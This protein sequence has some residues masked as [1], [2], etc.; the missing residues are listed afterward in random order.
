MM[1]RKPLDASAIALMLGLCVFWGLQQVAVKL[2]LPHMGAIMQ[3][4]LR[5]AIAAMLVCI[6]IWWRGGASL[7]AGTLR[8]GMTAGTLFA[9]EFLCVAAGLEFTTAS[10]MSVFLYTAP[11]FTVL[12]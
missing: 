11:V 4:G 3:I 2:A 10:H 6:V 5:S 1:E 9:I 7:T 12:G 8:A